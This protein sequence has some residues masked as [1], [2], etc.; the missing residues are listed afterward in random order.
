M[1]NKCL[2]KEII[3]GIRKYLEL[4]DNESSCTK[5]DTV[6]YNK[7]YVFDLYPSSWQTS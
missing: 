7:K 4:A 6:I 3:I 5:C 1:S 2:K